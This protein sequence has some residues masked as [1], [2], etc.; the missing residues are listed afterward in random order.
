[1]TILPS[2]I[3]LSSSRS[4]PKCCKFVHHVGEMEHESILQKRLTFS[5]NPS[6]K[7][8]PKQ[9]MIGSH[10]L[11]CTPFSENS[12]QHNLS[13]KNMPG[14]HFLNC[15]Y[16]NISIHHKKLSSQ[17]MR[18]MMWKSYHCTKKW[19]FSMQNWKSVR[20]PHPT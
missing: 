6:C 16:P 17:E 1:M 2:Q 18:F 7:V 14:S 20:F 15:N 11:H 19:K 5:V 9:V 10:C 12:F 13:N 3:C 8:S 4:T